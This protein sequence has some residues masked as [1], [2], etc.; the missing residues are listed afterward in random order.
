MSSCVC[1]LITTHMYMPHCSQIAIAF[2]FCPILHTLI[3]F[4]S[5]HIFSLYPPDQLTMPGELSQLLNGY[6]Q[7]FVLHRSTLVVNSETAIMR[8]LIRTCL[9]VQQVKLA[10]VSRAASSWLRYPAF[11]ILACWSMELRRARR[12]NTCHRTWR[13]GQRVVGGSKSRAVW[14][15]E[16]V[17][18][19][20]LCV[21][22]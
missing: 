15:Y 6:S 16:G 1:V 9:R 4:Y 12:H 20:R 17:A 21:E 11:I 10:K 5:E 7:H 8:L 13:C 22:V 3:F 14:M 2:I 18:V 19:M